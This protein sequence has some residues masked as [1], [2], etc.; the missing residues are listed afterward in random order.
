MI[1]DHLKLV[2]DKKTPD[3]TSDMNIEIKPTVQFPDHQKLTDLIDLIG[4][5]P[6]SEKAWDLMP[7]YVVTC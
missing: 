4:R 1:K 2:F 6:E 3:R 7:P 5:R